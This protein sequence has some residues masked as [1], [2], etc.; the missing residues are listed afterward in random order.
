MTFFF[1]QKPKKKKNKLCSEKCYGVPPSGGIPVWTTCW[2][3]FINWTNENKNSKLFYRIWDDM[4][5]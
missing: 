4:A 1:C 5:S 2:T 3:L